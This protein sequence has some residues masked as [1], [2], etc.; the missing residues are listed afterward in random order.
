MQFAIANQANLS[1]L[2]GANTQPS[3]TSA[4][5]LSI[6]ELNWVGGGEGGSGIK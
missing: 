4:R 1:V 6:D 3:D 5:E 2:V